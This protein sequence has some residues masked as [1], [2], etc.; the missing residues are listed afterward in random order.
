MLTQCVQQVLYHETVF[1][2]VRPEMAFE[3]TFRLYNFLHR[4]IVD[5][6]YLR[7]W[8][9]SKIGK[10]I[11]KDTYP[12]LTSGR[13][14][15]HNSDSGGEE[16]DQQHAPSG[17]LEDQ[18][19]QESLKEAGYE[20]TP[21][22]DMLLPITPVCTLHLLL[23]RVTNR[24]D[25]QLKPNMRRATSLDGLDVVLKLV[26]DDMDEIAILKHLNE[27]KRAGNHTIE[28]HGIIQTPI[29]NAIALPWRIPLMEYID[30]YHPPKS[31]SS[32]PD[33]FLEG[34]AFLHE[35]RVAHLDLKPG[36][37]VVDDMDHERIH[38]PRLVII[39][40]GLSMFIK[41]EHT[42]TKGFC[43]TPPWVAPEV[44]TCDGP[45]MTYSPI[46]ADRWACGRMVYHLK[47]LL[48]GGN[49][50]SRVRM[51]EEVE[52]FTDRLMSSDPRA[53]PSVKEVLDAYRANAKGG[54][55]QIAKVEESDGMY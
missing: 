24:T 34:V 7:G 27:I 28:L 5:S 20:L 8:E 29:A 10:D 6:R 40:F 25:Q 4:A 54:V 47:K 50:A 53:R 9:L 18:M 52:V 49:D 23:K 11:P 2:L 26:D 37:V 45:E 3:F 13:K 41:D 48:L 32:F 16:T 44:G 35:Y 33:Q 55:E 46:L 51:Q 39:D 30:F 19:M 17:H 31:A 38:P 42:T 15:K 22:D 14:R 1:N 12:T 43:G 36:N 21:T